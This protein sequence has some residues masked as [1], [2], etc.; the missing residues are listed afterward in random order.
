MTHE[1]IYARL[2]K[3]APHIAFEASR[4]RDGQVVWD[5]NPEDDP[6]DEMD[7]YDIDVTATMVVMGELVVGTASLGDCWMKDEEEI[8][9]IHGYLPQKQKEAVEDLLSQVDD[10]FVIME[11]DAV[12]AFLKQEM[13]DRY[14][15][16][17]HVLP[18]S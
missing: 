7:T 16:Q 11:L 13:K 6:S 3:L 12:H 2:K 18:G 5:G 8:G 10:P 14:K 15:E 4:T 17:Q 1:E 9:D